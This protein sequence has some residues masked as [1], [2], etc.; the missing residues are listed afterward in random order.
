MSGGSLQVGQSWA[1]MSVTE[2]TVRRGRHRASLGCE[3]ARGYRPAGPVVVRP[4]HSA[5][6][7]KVERRQHLEPS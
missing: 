3:G 7:A 1:K 6:G 5:F 4:L 2:G